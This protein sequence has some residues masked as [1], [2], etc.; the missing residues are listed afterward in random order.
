MW[1]LVLNTPVEQYMIDAPISKDGTSM[2]FGKYNCVTISHD[3]ADP[4][5]ASSVLAASIS[6]A[7][8]KYLSSTDAK[9]F[10]TFA[11]PWSQN[12]STL[13]SITVRVCDEHVKKQ[14]ALKPPGD[15]G[16]WVN[17]FYSD[18]STM[19]KGS[20][21]NHTYTLVFFSIRTYAL[22]ICER[23]RVSK[24]CG[25]PM[26]QKWSMQPEPVVVHS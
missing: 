6:D 16:K 1:Y 12:S 17:F 4:C 25:D 22:G 7:Q 18:V 11:K 2:G 26:E 15:K 13:K 8:K 5:R 20:S 9:G 14:H 10:V 3:T 19:P 24:T 21:L 23:W